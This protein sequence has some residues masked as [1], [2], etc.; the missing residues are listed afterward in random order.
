MG[1]PA[2]G[3]SGITDIVIG[4][5]F[6]FIVIRKLANRKIHSQTMPVFSINPLHWL[7]LR[8][9]IVLALSCIETSSKEYTYYLV[10]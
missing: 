9:F 1:S 5:A 3:T 6:D 10:D 7:D 8:H 4:L 2:L